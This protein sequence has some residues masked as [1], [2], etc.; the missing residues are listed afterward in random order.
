MLCFTNWIHDRNYHRDLLTLTPSPAQ[1]QPSD[2]QCPQDTLHSCGKQCGDYRLE[3]TNNYCE[4]ILRVKCSI[5]DPGCGQDNDGA[6]LRTNFLVCVSF[7]GSSRFFY[8]QSRLVQS[9]CKIQYFS[10]KNN[11]TYNYICSIIIYNLYNICRWWQYLLLFDNYWSDR[12][13]SSLW[14]GCICCWT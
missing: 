4:E 7:L 10:C 14:Q 2:L 6:I 3:S 12:S 11:L 9:C 1:P 13:S 5:V 8:L